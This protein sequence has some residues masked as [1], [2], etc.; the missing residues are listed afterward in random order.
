[1][2]NQTQIFLFPAFVLKYL[3]NET[4]LIQNAEID[5]K[6]KLK[7]VSELCDCHIENFHVNENNFY[8]QELENQL[9]TYIL[10]CCFSD[11]LKNKNIQPDINVGLSMGLYAAMYSAGCISFNDGA[12]LIRRVYDAEKNITG[13]NEFSMLNIIG[14]SRNDIDELIV[15]F[16]LHCEVVIQNGPFSFIISGVKH[17]IE[18]LQSF[19]CKEGALHTNRFPVKIPYH[20]SFISLSDNDKNNILKGIHISNP[21]SNLM[22]SICGELLSDSEDIS[23]EIFRNITQTVHWQSIMEK[24]NSKHQAVFYECGPGNSLSKIARFIN[25]IFDIRKFS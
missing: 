13:F 7:A 22:S 17:D 14:L 25:G 19:A 4:R 21:E 16:F 12:L 20:S 11:M 10:S 3:G 2:N 8:E 9:I 23:N 1:M 5:L 15:Q 18:R 24:M 6:S